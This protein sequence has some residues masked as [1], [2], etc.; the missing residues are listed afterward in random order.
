MVMLM[1]FLFFGDAFIYMGH[2]IVTGKLQFVSKTIEAI[3]ALEYLNT[4]LE[5]NSILESSSV[6]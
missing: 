6:F 2:T 4:V 5:C 3:K 1:K